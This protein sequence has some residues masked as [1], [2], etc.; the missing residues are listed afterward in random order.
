MAFCK[1][2]VLVPGLVLCTVGE[3]TALV[4][5]LWPRGQKDT[6]DCSGKYSQLLKRYNQVAGTKKQSYLFL[7]GR[8]FTGFCSPEFYLG[9]F[10]IP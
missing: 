2:L 3:Q 9:R 4:G 1:S 10:C 8:L 5:S 7:F 6:P